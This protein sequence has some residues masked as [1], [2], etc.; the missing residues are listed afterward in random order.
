MTTSTEHLSNS[1]V[2][3]ELMADASNQFGSSCACL[4]CSGKLE[5]SVTQLFDTR[6]GIEGDYEARR[7]SRC[8]LEALYPVPSPHELKRLYEAYYNFGGRERSLYAG[9]REWFFRSGM[10]RLWAALDGDICFY[11]R[12]GSGRLLDVGCNEGRGLKIYSH[13]GYQ[14]EGLELNES[15]AAVARE[16]GFAVHTDLLADFQPSAP[17]DAVVLSNVLEHSLDPVEML[18]D[19]RR[20]LRPG[21]QVWISCPNSRSWLRS[22]FGRYWINW[23]PPF[24]VVHFSP[25]SL[26]SL[27]TDAGFT[28]VELRQR[29]PSLWV[30]SSIISRL[31]AR[32]GRATRQLRNPLLLFGLMLGI[33]VLL[34]PLLYLGNRMG[35][36]DCL[37]VTATSDSGPGDASGGRESHTPE[38]V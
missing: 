16:A 34:F 24:H 14:V 28:G 7:C 3:A 27:L 30:A 23:H 21:G 38:I 26:I 36:G 20:V 31:F 37:V 29:T 15:A 35:R 10:H 18:R 2:P 13:N 6:F 17:F 11:T 5:P 1:S 25:G 33:R 19:V 8:G 12:A 4:V 9:I 32:R 22:A